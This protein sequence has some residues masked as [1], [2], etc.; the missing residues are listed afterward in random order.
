MLVLKIEINKATHDVGIKKTKYQ[1]NPCTSKLVSPSSLSEETLTGYW[2]C[3]LQ[4]R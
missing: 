2:K 3:S 1:D 4:R